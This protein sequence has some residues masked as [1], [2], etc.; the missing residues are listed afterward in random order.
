M[1]LWY[2]LVACKMLPIQMFSFIRYWITKKNWGGKVAHRGC[3]LDH[4]YRFKWMFRMTL[5]QC[6][7]ILLLGQVQTEIKLVTWREA[8][9]KMPWIIT[10][11]VDPFSAWAVHHH[12]LIRSW[13]GLPCPSSMRYAYFCKTEFTHVVDFMLCLFALVYVTQG[14]NKL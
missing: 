7:G 11:N 5:V 10:F 1:V 14:E 9:Q 13:E 6:L 3:L 4:Q 12:L 2:S 8:D